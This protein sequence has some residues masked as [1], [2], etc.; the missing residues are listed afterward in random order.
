[1]SIICHLTGPAQELF[2]K[3]FLLQLPKLFD[4]EVLC[5]LRQRASGFTCISLKILL[6]TAAKYSKAL[7]TMHGLQFLH[8]QGTDMTPN[9]LALVPWAYGHRVQYAVSPGSFIIILTGLNNNK[10]TDGDKFNNI[11]SNPTPLLWT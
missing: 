5:V 2:E 10:L 1:M 11:S 7:S 6:Q 8:I 4:L 3:P 9:N